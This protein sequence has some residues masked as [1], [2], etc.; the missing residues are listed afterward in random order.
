MIACDWYL[1]TEVF[2]PMTHS[3]HEV[4]K[5]ERLLADAI[6]TGNVDTIDKLVHDELLCVIPSGETITK[7]MDMA[8]HNARQM[9]VEKLTVSINDIHIIGDC[10]ISISVYD[11]NG[12]MMGNPIEGKFKYLRVWKEFSDGIKVIA[13]TCTRM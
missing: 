9:I 5:H 8:A 13:A 6:Q 1:N 10:A 2:N 11:T 7:A 4:E 3:K 12:S